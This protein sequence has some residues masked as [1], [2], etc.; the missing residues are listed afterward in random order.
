MSFFFHTCL[1]NYVYLFFKKQCFLSTHTFSLLFCFF[2]PLF[3]FTFVLSFLFLFL[4]ISLVLYC[5]LS[6]HS[7]SFDNQQRG[8]RGNPF[9]A[10]AVLL[11]P[12]GKI[13]SWFLG[14]EKYKVALLSPGSSLHYSFFH[15]NLPLSH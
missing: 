10:P 13:A 7:L 14:R 2:V 8:H 9:F 3:P 1:T 6:F 15:L 5:H 4:L 11:C 12:S